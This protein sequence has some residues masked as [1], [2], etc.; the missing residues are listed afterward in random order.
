M[1][2][3]GA[4]L[5][6]IALGFT[7]VAFG[8]KVKYKDLMVL[9]NA[10]QYDQ[11][12]PHLKR[13]LAENTDNVSAYLYMGIIYQEKSAKSD[14]LKQTDALISNIDSAIFFYNKAFPR[15]TEKEVKKNDENYL[16]YTRRDLRTGE[17]GVTLSD[18]LL[19]V[20]TRIKSLREKTE[21]V[22]KLKKYYEDA[23]AQYGRANAMYKNFQSRFKTKK[24][25]YLQSD[26]EMILELE[27]LAVTFDSSQVSFK[28]YKTTSQAVGKTG[29][30]QLV[31]LQEI[32]DFK[33]DGSSLIDFTEN[34][35]KLWDYSE[36][37]KKTVRIVRDEVY[38]LRKELIS[39]DAKLNKLRGKIKKDSSNVNVGEL[40]GN[41]VFNE[42]KKWDT[43]P[44]PALLFHVKITEIRYMAELALQATLNGNDDIPKRINLIK[45]QQII[46][47][48]LDSL[49]SSFVNRDWD[50]D[51]IKYKSFI[52]NSYGTTAVLKNFGKAM[53]EMTKR[54]VIAKKKEL[55]ENLSLLQWVVVES[56]SIPLFYDVS[57]FSK[58]KPLVIN[59][60]YTAGI[61]M[62]DS[63][64]VGYFYTVTPSRTTDLKVN[65]SVD[66]VSITLRD[67]PLIK[68]LSLNATDQY[69]FILFY[70]ESKIDGK[71]PVTL[72]KIGRIGGLE[73]STTFTTELAPVELKLTA[74]T[75]ELSI[76]TSS[77]D[78]NSKM[79]VIDKTGKRL[80]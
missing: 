16:M 42:L 51:A 12:E 71:I 21:R 55:D 68:G 66:S 53:L 32:S 76:K 52:T 80:Q 44:M 18:I 39:F 75:G 27:R 61:T 26:D 20:E 54:D 46:L 6:F 78:G 30:N 37:T 72:A 24:E 43:D 1:I 70:S 7:G 58:F 56:D 34:D 41:T 2:R 48:E 5:L 74:S 40:K 57:E 9:L 13:Y 10:K 25:L 47:K 38:P 77:P 60:K 17:F 62:M 15:I 73:W 49:A 14:V 65:F 35:L 28:S 23:V 19:D 45:Q 36:W 63:L 79:V 29:Y 11:A 59:E 8:Q 64:V 4:F 50:E 67:L 31:N 33:K 22:N 3:K 69:Y